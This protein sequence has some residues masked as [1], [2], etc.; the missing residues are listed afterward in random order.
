MSVEEAKYTVLEKEGNFE[1]RQYEPCVVAETIVEA[2][3]DRAGNIAFRRLYDYIS[4][5]NRKRESIAMTAPVSQQ[6]GSE[7]IAMTAP[8]SQQAGSEK[9]AMTAPVSQQRSE[10]K[11]AIS[12]MMPAQHTMQTLP[13]PMDPAVV[14]REIP[15]RKMAAVRYSGT[16]GRA[17]YEQ[18][19]A[20]LEAFIRDR[21][22]NIVGEPIFARYNPPFLPFFL[23]RNEVLIPV[24]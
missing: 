11:W 2:D 4:G 20:R 19:K 21:G 15:A 16:W 8:V 3:F 18:N 5:Y 7:K 14:L 24:E 12:F 6:T 1:V 10:D 17:R 22:M 23:R 9:I 13:E